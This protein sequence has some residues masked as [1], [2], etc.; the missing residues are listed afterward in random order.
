MQK[1]NPKFLQGFSNMQFRTKYA[2]LMEKLCNW[3]V[4]YLA[5]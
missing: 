4:Y 1:L 5:A 2:V 3:K